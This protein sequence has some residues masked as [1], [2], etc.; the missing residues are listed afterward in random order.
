MI[1]IPIISL[2]GKAKVAC[3]EAKCNYKYALGSQHDVINDAEISR[4]SSI[5][6][7]LHNARIQ[8][9][10]NT[11]VTCNNVY[12]NILHTY[13]YPIGLH[14]AYCTVVRDRFAPLCY[15]VDNLKLHVFPPQE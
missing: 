9:M 1:V 13:I 10:I 4:V 7:S 14:F 11:H 6:P 8:F 3:K 15:A 5:L 2:W 12:S